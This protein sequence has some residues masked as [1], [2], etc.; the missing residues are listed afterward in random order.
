ML[1]HSSHLDPAHGSFLLT[2]V[3]QLGGIW[4]PQSKPIWNSVDDNIFTS[5][6]EFCFCP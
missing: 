5:C 1:C 3:V 6:P 2:T 4:A